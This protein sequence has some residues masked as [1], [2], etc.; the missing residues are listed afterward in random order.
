MK[1]SAKAAARRAREEARL[2]RRGGARVVDETAADEAA[3]VDVAAADNPP[4]T[5][6][7]DGRPENVRTG[8]AGAPR[9]ASR[10]D[11]MAPAPAGPRKASRADDA[12]APIAGRQGL[13]QLPYALVLAGIVLGLALMCIAGQPVKSGTLVIA[14]ALL[15]GSVARLVLPDRR[16]GL[17]RSRRR[18]VD[19]G[20]L[21]ALGVGLL[22]AGLIVQVPG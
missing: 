18:L 3:A 1:H 13:A 22:V 21:T 19:V 9:N 15:A 12:A 7:Q 20:M 17:L 5:P 6:V 10:A 4:A 8:A 11:D 16:V 2:A 14:G